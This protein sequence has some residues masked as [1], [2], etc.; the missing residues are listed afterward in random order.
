[1][2]FSSNKQITIKLYH[3]MGSG[4]I[5]FVVILAHFTQE[6]YFLTFFPDDAYKFR[7]TLMLPSPKERDAVMKQDS[8][9]SED[10]QNLKVSFLEISFVNSS[11]E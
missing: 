3:S 6:D 1:M 10:V 2:S 7:G 11:S 8:L 5:E 4:K 9:S